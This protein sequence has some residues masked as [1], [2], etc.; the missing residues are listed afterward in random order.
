MFPL[1]AILIRLLDSP[2]TVRVHYIIQ[3]C[4]FAIFVASVGMGIWMA[5][6]TNL[7]GLIHV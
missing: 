5:K 2:Y 1:G 6:W 7:V 3:I 4:A